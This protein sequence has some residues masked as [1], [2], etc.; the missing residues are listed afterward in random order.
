[1][2]IIKN[3]Q[4]KF[5]GDHRQGL[6]GFVNIYPKE[7]LYSALKL[8][9]AVSL[10]LSI[11]FLNINDWNYLDKI[12]G[13]LDLSMQ[14]LPNLLGFMLGGFAIFLGFTDREFIEKISYFNPDEKSLFQ[15][16]SYAFTFSLLAIS[17]SL[18]VVVVS[19]LIVGASSLLPFHYTNYLNAFFYWVLLFLL[20]VT[21][22]SLY[23]IVI[24]LF[25]MA[26][27]YHASLSI[28]KAKDQTKNDD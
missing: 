18:F 4:E 16:I 19:K 8:P 27:S 13:I 3:N 21:L 15:L 1:M 17:I 12:R 5:R 14:I 26:Q 7:K 6:K 28:K 23:Q 2:E 10:L 24:I 25:D 11:V 9:F 20:L 22:Y